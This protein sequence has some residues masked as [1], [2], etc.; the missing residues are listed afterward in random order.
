LRESGQLWSNNAGGASRQ[1][2]FLHPAGGTDVSAVTF[3]ERLA[4]QKVAGLP[5]SRI[6]RYR[7][8]IENHHE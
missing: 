7:A 6:R 3:R 2:M 4:R 5:P 1:Y 8:S